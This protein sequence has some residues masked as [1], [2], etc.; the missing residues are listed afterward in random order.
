MSKKI[1][2]IQLLYDKRHEFKK[3][4]LNAFLKNISQYKFS[5]S[6]NI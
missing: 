2:E 1:L 6:K 5:N 3:Q 4:K